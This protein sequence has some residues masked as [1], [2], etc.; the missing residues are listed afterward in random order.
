MSRA[1]QAELLCAAFLG[2]LDGLMSGHADAEQPATLR[3]MEQFLASRLRGDV[4][5][6]DLCRQF[7]VSRSTVYRLFEPHG[8]VSAYLGRMR[9]ERAY[10][11]LR[12]ADPTRT[13]L[14]GHP[15]LRCPDTSPAAVGVRSKVP[16]VAAAHPRRVCCW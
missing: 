13:L 16:A 6:E 12:Q 8:G 11:D 10:A 9:L 2:F 14:P 15:R 5:V 3:S 7:N 4:G 1:G